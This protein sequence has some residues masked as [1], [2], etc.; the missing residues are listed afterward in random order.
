[1]SERDAADAGEQRL[2]ALLQELDRCEDL[3]EELD[4]LGL[5]T[6]EEVERRM[7]ELNERI[8]ALGGD[9]AP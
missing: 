4:D 8:D 7:A 1:M 9:A 6:R 5:R 3:L 2:Y